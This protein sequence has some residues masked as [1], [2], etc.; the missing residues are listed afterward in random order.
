MSQVKC[1][2]PHLTGHGIWIFC[3]SAVTERRL[4]VGPSWR[5]RRVLRT[6]RDPKRP[7]LLENTTLILVSF[8]GRMV[9]VIWPMDR[10]LG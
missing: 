5:P 4:I 10:S 3:L 2:G 1:E 7:A 9:E 6:L 8:T